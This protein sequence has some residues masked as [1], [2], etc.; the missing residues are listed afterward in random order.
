[1]KTQLEALGKVKVVVDRAEQ[2]LGDIEAPYNTRIA[3]LTQTIS[4]IRGRIREIEDELAENP[5]YQQINLLVTE[6]QTAFLSARGIA[7][8]AVKEYYN[9]YGF[10]S[11]KK[12]QWFDGFN[13]KV[14]E[15]TVRTIVD[16]EAMFEAARD[17]NV[18]EKVIKSVRPVLNRGAWNKWIDL[19]GPPGVEVSQKVSVTIERMVENDEG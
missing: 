7:K 3:E 4:A 11:G 9:E 19:I 6:S 12:S 2:H 15:T 8:E 14:K 17:G 16:T 5:E 10:P 1:M 18:Y 13:L